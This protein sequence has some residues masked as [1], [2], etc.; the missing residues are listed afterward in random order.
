MTFDTYFRA[1]SCA[2]V[3]CG[4]LALVLAGGVGAWLAVAFACVMAASWVTAG[5]RWQ[6]SERAGMWVVLAALPLFYLDWQFQNAV[7]GPEGKILAG[8]TALVHFTLLLTSVKLFQVKSDRDWLFLYL[9]SFF[10]V[11]LAAA[12]SASPLFL[13]GLALYLFSALLAVVCFE[14]RKAS[15]LAPH[16]ESRLLVAND[17][18]FLRRGKRSRRASSAHRRLPAAALCLF[19]LIAGLA[20]PI[21]FIA[22]RASEGA[23]AMPGGAASTG[24]V[25][26][27]DR[28]R[29]GDIGRLQQ[30]NQLVM[31]VRVEGPGEGAPTKRP[32]WR[33]V[34]L[35]NFDGRH[36]KQ[37]PGA[38]RTELPNERG[39]FQLGT[40]EDLARLTTQTFYVEAIDTPVVF[41]APRA[42]AIQGGLPYVRRDSEDGLSSRPHPQE[43]VSYRVYSD[44]F[45]PPE[46]RLRADRMPDPRGSTPNL[47]REIEDYIQLP[48]TLDTR[49]A[50]LA[51]TIVRDAKARN[52]Y[53]AARAIEA[54]LNSNQY[55][56]GYFYSLDMRASGEDPLADFL[57]NVRGGHCE[58]FSTA[59]AVM[60]RSLRV[61]ARVVN[62][63][64]T[65]EYNPAADAYV[66]RQADAH[67]W[68]EVYFTEADAWVTFDPTPAAGRPSGAETSGLGGRLGQY[69]DALELFWIQYVVAYDRQGQRSLA[70]TLRSTFNSYGDAATE[71]ASGLSARLAA[72]NSSAGWLGFVASPQVFV[73]GAAL[74][75]LAALLLLGR[76]GF[77]PRL[78]RR[79]GRGDDGGGRSAVEFYERMTKALEA[80]GSKRGA[81]ETPLEFAEKVGAEEVLAITRAYN[82]V[83]FGGRGLSPDEA[84]RIDVWLKDLEG[85][86]N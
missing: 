48:A 83:R 47:R 36:W 71:S 1:C 44:T 17:P 67:S 6:L 54:H 42:V 78:R 51:W 41:A 5:T 49:I 7:V 59:M 14:L 23:L 30:S 80:R 79:G 66:V 18:K 35:D 65:G 70:R 58:Y 55:G 52:T 60:L 57:F 13:L 39:L 21:F 2:M 27:S 86:V 31:R 69:A 85:T 37:T 38:S 33:G 24:Y 53:D 64:Q 81:D 75:G 40:T 9:I 84:Q 34:A 10:E 82:S 32:R 77:G 50:S 20:L 73:P 29:L 28:M 43:R 15:R 25:G 8:V 26:F 46:E 22:P 45:E 61:P 3:A 68:V 12:L 72:W 4:V 76:K 74:A 16:A 63:F 19:L 56:G 62:G 11:L